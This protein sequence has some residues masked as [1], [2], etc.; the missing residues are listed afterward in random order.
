[1]ARRRERSIRRINLLVVRRMATSAIL[2]SRIRHRVH[3]G[4][5]CDGHD[6]QQGDDLKRNDLMVMVMVI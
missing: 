5:E 3:E 1:M 2:L 4:H 6:E